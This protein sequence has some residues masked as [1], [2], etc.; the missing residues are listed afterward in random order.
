MTWYQTY[1][2]QYVPL[3]VSN[4]LEPGCLA[5]LLLLAIQRES[6]QLVVAGAHQAEY[7]VWL[8]SPDDGGL[9]I[10]NALEALKQEFPNQSLVFRYIPS[11]APIQWAQ[12]ESPWFKYTMLEPWRRP[13]VKIEDPTF[14]KGYLAQKYKRR[15]T[16]SYFNQLRKYGDLRFE[17]LNGEEALTGVLDELIRYYD[18]RQMAM[19]GDAPFRGDARKKP[20]HLAM[21]REANL[22]HVTVL[23]AGERIVSSQFGVA[24]KNEL[25]LAMPIFSPFF[26]DQSPITLHYLLLVEKALEEGYK[27][28]DMTPGESGFKDRFA[29]EHEQVHILRVFFSSGDRRRLKSRLTIEAAVRSVLRRMNVSPAKVRERF[30][31]FRKI[32]AR[33]HL[34]DIPKLVGNR[35]V[36]IGKWIHSKDESRAYLAFPADSA[37]PENPSLMR[38]DCLDDLMDFAPLELWQDKQTFLSESLRRLERKSHSYTRVEKGRLAHFGWMNEDQREAVFPEVGQRLHL[39][40]GT[41][42]LY[43][44]YTDP[45][46][47]GKGLYKASMRQILHD[48]ASLASTKRMFIAVLA[49][50]KASRQAIEGLGFAYSFSLFR[51][52]FFG[53]VKTWASPLPEGWQ[54]EAISKQKETG[55]PGEE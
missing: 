48:A 17:R 46:S 2:Q 13:I 44:F 30:D 49:D 7:Q 15:S 22:L 43:D 32:F 5:G 54:A 31:S 14:V 12:K 40:E 38:K 34:R 51:S 26:A 55:A 50:N 37:R 41:A 6:G 11:G 29:T 24:S 18:S 9:F 36:R 20:F 33:M 4:E 28:L 35:M 16:K 45:P 3:V 8:S 47:R 19:H 25:I 27:I 21:M 42:V 10:T 39:P 53:G 23:R 52:R 1:E